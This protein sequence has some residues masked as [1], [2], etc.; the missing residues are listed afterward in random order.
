MATYSVLS[1]V[2][3]WQASFQSTNIR[4]TQLG[5]IIIFMID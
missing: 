4:E 2:V 1:L 3:A 5:H